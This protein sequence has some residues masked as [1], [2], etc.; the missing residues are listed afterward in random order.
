MKTQKGFTIIEL[1]VVILLLGILTATALPRFMDI[2]D[3]AHSA[4]VDGVVGGLNTGMALFHAQWMA[5]GQPQGSALTGFGDATLWPTSSGYP[6]DA[7]NGAVD[8]HA[9][10]LAVYN[11]V[12]QPG[13]PNAVAIAAL[14]VN[15]EGNVETA[16]AASPTADIIVAFDGAG[17]CNF[18]YMGQYREGTS[19]NQV[20]IPKLAYDSSTGA[21]TQALQTFQLD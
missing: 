7:T 1:V 9:D 3:D 18:Y 8:D 12:L 5:K 2:T 14:S 4:A 16:A 15:D 11:G 10:C 13:R 17:V 6:A 21:V 19:T 20:N